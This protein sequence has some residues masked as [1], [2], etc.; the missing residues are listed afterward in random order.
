MA[1]LLSRKPCLVPFLWGPLTYLLALERMKS[2]SLS[3]I[4]PFCRVSSSICPRPYILG[5]V[6]DKFGNFHYPHPVLIENKPGDARGTL[7]SLNKYRRLLRKGELALLA[8]DKLAGDT[9]Q[10]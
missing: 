6:I 2:F 3:F 8:L 4:Y 1:P 10:E 9:T 7:W 5:K